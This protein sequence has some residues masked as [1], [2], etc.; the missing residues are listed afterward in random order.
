MS[1]ELFPTIAAVALTYA[2]FITYQFARVVKACHK[3][4]YH[5]KVT[6]LAMSLIVV[7]VVDEDWSL[8]PK[9]T[10]MSAQAHGNA[11]AQSALKTAHEVAAKHGFPQ[12]KR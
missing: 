6:T 11:I 4:D 7:G 8:P 10:G 5:R 2:L 3:I 1:F 9:P 12:V